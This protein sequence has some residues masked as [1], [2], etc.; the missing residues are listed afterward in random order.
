MD[1]KR[2]MEGRRQ[3]HKDLLIVGMGDLHYYGGLPPSGLSRI[4]EGTTF[5]RLERHHLPKLSKKVLKCRDEVKTVIDEFT[6][7]NLAVMW[8]SSE[9]V[10]V[11]EGYM[12]EEISPIIF[13]E[14]YVDKATESGHTNV[15]RTEQNQKWHRILTV[16]EKDRLVIMLV[17][18]FLRVR[19]HMIDPSILDALVEISVAQS[20]VIS[21]YKHAVDLRLVHA[22]IVFNRSAQGSAIEM[23]AIYDLACS[24]E[25]AE[26]HCTAAALFKDI[27]MAQEFG[28]QI[29]PEITKANICRKIARA[30]FN[31]GNYTEAE[32]FAVLT[33]HETGLD[34][35][36][37]KM[38]LQA[39]I[40]I[41]HLEDVFEHHPMTVM[42]FLLNIYSFHQQCIMCNLRSSEMDYKVWK[43]YV[44]LVLLLECAEM[45]SKS[46]WLAPEILE[47][48]PMDILRKKY[49]PHTA[50]RLIQVA[51]MMRTVE[52]Y[53][54]NF[55]RTSQVIMILRICYQRSQSPTLAKNK[56]NALSNRRQ[57][58]R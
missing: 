21:I 26:D 55:F 8:Y 49:K 51:F 4:P 48:N 29:D 44:I 28:I 46:R 1:I 2:D 32:T 15:I 3:Y 5:K 35:Y 45:T 52:E 24:M 18:R 7:N 11:I 12:P 9:R 25:M 17:Q 14:I 37:L 50:E 23:E 43:V 20:F 33:L 40:G 22:D 27:L 34:G 47:N 57:K 38:V 13:I 41:S 53:H 36:T 39:P 56:L 19:G 6:S 54:V 31:G 10:V 58:Q 30:S 42:A 16:D